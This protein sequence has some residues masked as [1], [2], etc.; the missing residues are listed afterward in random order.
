MSNSSSNSDS[1]STSSVI[2]TSASMASLAA[3]RKRK[4][5]S[6]QQ[7]LP[8]LY[9]GAAAATTSTTTSSK[10]QRAT[11]GASPH[12]STAPTRSDTDRHTHVHHHHHV[13]VHGLDAATAQDLAW[14]QATTSWSTPAAAAPASSDYHQ[15][16]TAVKGVEEL[17]ETLG[18]QGVHRVG[19]PPEHVSIAEELFL[20]QAFSRSDENT[21]HR[22]QALPLL[23]VPNASPIQ[24]D[25]E[26]APQLQTVEDD[27]T[28][29][30]S[31]SSSPDAFSP[32][33]TTGLH[34]PGIDLDLIDTLEVGD[35]PPS[36]FPPGTFRTATAATHSQVQRLAGMAATQPPQAAASAPPPAPAPACAPAPAAVPAHEVTTTTATAAATAAAA[37]DVD[38]GVSSQ[39][40]QT[41]QDH[42]RRSG[43]LVSLM[44][45]EGRTAMAK[46]QQQQRKDAAA[47]R[48]QK[49]GI[50][51]RQKAATQQ[52]NIM[53]S[54]LTS[55][56]VGLAATSGRSAKG[57]LSA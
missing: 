3:S 57:T 44:F 51:A 34:S 52:H 22:A 55:I 37:L 25:V 38:M 41:Q 53:A 1:S 47:A 45:V 14:L 2:A 46:Y 56:D 18:Q 50:A 13:H 8:S 32:Y 26:H 30:Y 24:V 9:R 19:P 27:G 4:L 16:A 17:A 10:A 42:Q 23:Q 20:M 48:R 39:Q 49:R 7:E 43:D 36:A 5:D 12:S 31:G 11:L 35:H 21:R 6:A 15:G 28:A 29:Y 40:Q 33:I 54:I